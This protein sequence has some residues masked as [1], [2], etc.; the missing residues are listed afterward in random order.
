MQTETLLLRQLPPSIA[1]ASDPR[2]SW[3]Q[4]PLA[5][6]SDAQLAGAVAAAIAAPKRD[7]D[8]SFLTHAPLELAARL[9][10]LPMAAESARDGVRRRIAA[11]AGEYARAGEEIETAAGRFAD[12]ASA[13]RA[14]KHAIVEGDAEG[15]DAALL[16]LIPRV[17][18]SALAA[19]LSADLLPMLGAAAHAPILLADLPK[20]EG[21][22]DGAGALLRAPVAMIAREAAFRLRWHEAASEEKFDGDAE[23]EL[24][25][26]LKDPPSV[27]SPSV[28]IAPIMLAVEADG[29]AARRLGDVTAAISGDA[30]ERAIL[31][32]A[33]FSMLQ[34]DPASAPYGWTHALT[35][36]L[37]VFGCA[38]F[39]A[40]KRA[41]VRVAATYALGFRATL[42]K[43]RLEARPPEPARGRDFRDVKPEA[44]AGAV[45]HADPAEFPRI[46]AALAARAATH[47]D[48]H[49]A[50]YTLACFEAA[51]RDP[52]AAR[53][54]LA[55]AARLGAWWD[56]HP[57]ERFE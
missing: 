19:A 4:S 17:P 16:F 18:A 41:L 42:G 25:E 31:R 12:D 2:D 20:L 6:L 54:Y 15:A 35:M 36:P 22:I 5:A 1:D 33:A 10:L 7:A 13:I 8:S 14:L 46:R 3:G 53:L 40:D 30:A 29:Y 24:F 44:A 57:D 37:G 43:V 47:R 52:E 32:I 48:T 9:N 56:A 38:P 28:Y 11:I 23:R 26:R 51:G 50:K 45:Y 49:L 39:V 21:R 27:S 34:D 55:A